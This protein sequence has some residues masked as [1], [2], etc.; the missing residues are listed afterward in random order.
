MAKEGKAPVLTPQQI[1]VVFKAAELTRHAKR[2]IG[3]LHCSFS[4]GMR[5]CEIRRL[6]V[7]DVL[8][9]DGKTLVD[10]INLLKM[11]TKGKKQRH[12][13]FSNPKARQAIS[14]YLQEKMSNGFNLDMEKPLFESQKGGEF[15]VEA[16]TVVF[17]RIFRLAG[18]ENAKSHSGRRTCLTMYYRRCRDIKSL[19]QIAGHESINTTQG[20]IDADPYK[21]GKIMR[22][23]YF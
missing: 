8:Q 22:E 1:R 19:Q 20:Y 10:N 4:L 9:A 23:S 14:E 18:L 17:K 21:L 11:M 5:A 16:I 13:P 3:I 12:V 2:N 6:R 7:C 15:T